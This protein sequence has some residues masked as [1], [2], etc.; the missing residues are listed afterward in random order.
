MPSYPIRNSV[1]NVFSGMDVQDDEEILFNE[2]LRDHD[3]APN[4]IKALCLDMRKFARWFVEAN[5]EP[6]CSTTITTADVGDFRRYLRDDCSQAVSTA[7]RA[8]VS[9]RQ[10]LRWVAD[11]GLIQSNPAAL[12]KEI[13]RQ[14]LAPQGL[15]PT[16][17]RKLLREVELRRDIRGK[18]IFTLFLFTGGRVG[19]LVNL[20]IENVEIKPRSGSVTFH[21]GKGGKMRVC[22]LPLKA[23]HALQ[24]YLNIRRPS[25][26]SRLFLGERGP[27]SSRGFQFLCDK[28]SHLIGIRLHPHLFRHTFAKECLRRGGNLVQLLGH[29]GLSTVQVYCCD[30]EEA[31]AEATDKIDY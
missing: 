2:F 9:I 14:K 25:S 12:I 17:V 26:S 6:Y 7:N 27:L 15:D 8:V 5:I 13:P 21:N 31:L 22:P 23:R 28:Y 16:E 3:Y 11:Q 30:T 19:D 4:T 20:D 18:A 1:D 10:Y 29:A 24:E